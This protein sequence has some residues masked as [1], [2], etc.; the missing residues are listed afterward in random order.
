MNLRDESGLDPGI[1]ERNP[2][3]RGSRGGFGLAQWTGPR[4]RALERFAEANGQ[5]VSN[6][7][8]QLDFIVHELNGTESEAYQRLLNTTNAGEA[9]DAFLRYYE[10]PAAAHRTRRSR[11]YLN[12][13]GGGF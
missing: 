5:D 6:P 8:V 12:G 3:V 1:N 9:A 11:R 10:R 4:R 2:V 13:G 7:D